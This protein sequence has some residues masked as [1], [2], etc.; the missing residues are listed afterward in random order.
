MLL[1]HN[2]AQ[3]HLLRPRPD[4][5]LSARS[6]NSPESVTREVANGLATLKYKFNFPTLLPFQLVI[7]LSAQDKFGAPFSIPI[8]VGDGAASIGVAFEGQL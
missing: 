6:R 4:L 8:F 2:R 7:E 5:P 3:Q 1:K